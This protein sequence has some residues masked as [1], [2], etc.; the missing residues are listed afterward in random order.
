MN[1]L[2]PAIG[3]FTGIL[4]QQGHIVDLFDSTNWIIPDEEFDSDKEKEKM[5]TARPYDDSKLWSDIRRTDV[6]E[7]FRAKVLVFKP[8][9]LAVSVNEDMFPLAKRLLSCVG[10]LSIPTIMGGV[11]ATFATEKCIRLPEVTMVCVGEGENALSELCRRMERGLPIDDIPSLWVKGPTGIIKNPLGPPVDINNN[12][13]IDL[14]F[15]DESRLY[16]PMQGR[17]WRMLPVE[18]HRGCPFQCTYCNSPAQRRMYHEE[19]GI[20]YFRKKSFDAIRNE[21]LYYKDEL[22]AE[23]LYFWA[24]TFLAYPDKDFDAFCEMYE[25]IRLPFWCQSRPET[26][27]K[28]RL[29]RLQNLGLFR[30]ALGIEHGNEVFRKQLLRRNVS[31]NVMIERFALLNELDIKFSVNNIIGFPTETRELAFDTIELN[32]NVYADS[33]NAYSFSPFHGTELRKLSEDLGYCDKDLIARSVMRPTMLNMPQFP[34]Q[35]IEGLRRCF[36][37]YARMP[38]DRW[39]EIE[40]AEALTPEG[41]HIWQT[42]RDECQEKYVNFD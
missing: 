35:A 14:A 34:P 25:E 40:R 29:V 32:R 39:K 41:D 23:A 31:N 6:C 16:R 10:D 33:A 4:R 13:R 30:I 42:L 27:S 28:N 3:L 38:K 8:D 24:D 1:M 18:T 37:L 11:F 36:T 19:T 2:P 9:L 26:I 15:F 7:D 5:L 22:K 17:V 20:S 21:L 12:P